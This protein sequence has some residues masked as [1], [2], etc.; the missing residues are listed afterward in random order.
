MVFFQSV[1]FWGEKRIKTY[2]S[3]QWNT[4][5]QPRSKDSYFQVTAS[6]PHTPDRPKKSQGVCLSLRKRCCE[7]LDSL[8][9]TYL[10]SR[11]PSCILFNPQGVC[12]LGWWNPRVL[13]TFCKIASH[14]KTSVSEKCGCIQLYI[15]NMLLVSSFL[16]VKFHIKCSK[17]LDTYSKLFFCKANNDFKICFI[18]W[19]FILLFAWKWNSHLAFAVGSSKQNWGGR[20]QVWCTCK[21]QVR[22]YE[23]PGELLTM[24]ILF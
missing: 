8:V 20:L 7:A 21:N 23:P 9:L 4:T 22:A 15:I 10:P 2:T 1:P 19:T 12:F 17:E 18:I 6:A 14:S 3:Y 16:W 13:T 11:F 24:Q 5:L